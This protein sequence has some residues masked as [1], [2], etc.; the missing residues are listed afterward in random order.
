M[1]TSEFIANVLPDRGKMLETYGVYLVPGQTNPG[2]YYVVRD[3][4][5]KI[6]GSI[7]KIRDVSGKNYQANVIR[8]S[9][10]G[11]LLAS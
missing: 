4:N 1:K 7:E 9:E 10:V 8:G 2:T 5:D 6:V 11:H 3:S